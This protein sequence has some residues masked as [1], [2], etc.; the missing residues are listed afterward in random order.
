MCKCGSFKNTF[1]MI[2]RLSELYFRFRRFIQQ[3]KQLK[4]ME[5]IEAWPDTYNEGYIH[6]FQPKPTKKFTRSNRST[7]FK[8]ILP[9]NIS[10]MITKAVLIIMRIVISYAMKWA[11]HCEFD[12]NSMETEIATWLEFSN[13]WK[14]IVEQIKASE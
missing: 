14:T 6:Q 11:S 4:T 8:D 13:G 2:T 5:I 12:G 10:Q 3:H 7:E 9:W 1:A